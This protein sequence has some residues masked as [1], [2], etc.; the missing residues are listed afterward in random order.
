M[1]V[2]KVKVLIQAVEN[3]SLLATAT[4]LGYTQAGLSHMMK[5][6]ESELGITL[7]Q[8]GKF[9]IKLTDEG[10]RLMPLFKELAVIDKLE[11]SRADLRAK[12]SIIRVA[13]IA[14]VIRTWLPDVMVS[15]NGSI[16]DIFFEIQESD[17]KDVSVA[18]PR[19]H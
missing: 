5:S 17:G 13:A 11:T 6:L 1:D 16:G 2:N 9:G 4:K 8:R 15:F 12:A 3:G 14:S 18:R 7:L 19:D 10:K